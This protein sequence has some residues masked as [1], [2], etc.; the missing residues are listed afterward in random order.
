MPLPSLSILLM[1]IL[2]PLVAGL[3][4]FFIPRLRNEFAFAGALVTFYYA[5][6]IFLLS[7]H[8]VMT[9]DYASIGPVAIGLR[10]DGLSA[11][12]LLALAFL[13]LTAVSFSLRYMRGSPGVGAF[14][15]FLLFT[16][17]A[18]AGV[19]MAGDLMLVLF[20]WGFLA[21]VLYG[22]LFLSRKDSAR[23]AMK[24]FI[25][26]AA[27]DLLMMTGIGILLF[28]LGSS[29]IAPELRIPLNSG[30]A[31]WAFLLLAAGAL[32]KAGSMPFHTWIP[33]AAETAPA[34]FLGF[35]PGAVDKLLGIY[36]LMRISTYIFDLSSSMAIRNV[37]MGIG[38]LTVL[39]AVL[40]AMVQKEA[41]RLLSFHAVSQ[42]GYM[43]LGIGTGN[44]IGIAGG[45]FH[46]VNHALYKS[47]LFY[48]TGAI[49]HWT[50]ETRLDRLGGLANKMPVTTISFL[51]AALAIS[52]VPPL[53]GF[54]SK[55]LVYQGILQLGA[56]GNRIYPLF[57]VAAMLGSV[58]TLASFLKLLH[59]IFL[60]AGSPIT[61]KVRE[62]GLPMWLPNILQA[63]VC[64]VFGVFALS[65][66]MRL[67]ILPSLH[68]DDAAMALGAGWL[69][70]FYQP[71]LVTGLLLIGIALGIVIY[72]VGTVAKPKTR[73]VFVGGEQLVGEEARMPGTEFYGPL[74]QLGPLH[75][76]FASAETGAYDMYNIALK[77]ARG[78]SGFVFAYVDRTVDKFYLVASDIVMMLGRGVQ[79]FA[80]WFFLL[81]LI[82]LFVFAGTGNLTA[83]QY[84]AI[85]LMV[86]A[87]LIAL[88]EDSFPRYM[89]LI[90]LTQLGFI[91]LAF[92]RGGT[93]GALSGL[94]QIYNSAVA[95]A[96]IFLAW[97]LLQRAHP[98][99]RISDY[100]GISETMPMVA[101][102]FIIGGL[103]L[104]G[105]PPSGNFFSKYLLASIY[106][107][108]MT[109]T[110]IIIFVAMLMLAVHLRIIS[111]SMFGKPN[112]ELHGRRDRLYYVTLGAIILCL[113]NIVLAKPIIALLSWA[114]GVSVQ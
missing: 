34:S 67:F 19:F 98:S 52:G 62:V 105:M 2:I 11:F 40:M 13:G 50:K 55:W 110:M 45:L 26:A 69:T 104:A 92:A 108:N 90:V 100:R 70:G 25:I 94:F 86:G 64:V 59:S 31:I 113:S 93:I 18:A 24:G 56:E 96:C 77:V 4:S 53:N 88:V 14:Y 63:A 89:V 71:S 91:I 61:E 83:I 47:T 111:Q 15:L 54:V 76:L 46:M 58:F 20:F 97:R 29:Q 5:L 42:V 3:L 36:L 48:S 27:A 73:D 75:A 74:K 65:V 82:P 9:Y 39:A 66:P 103:S 80:G 51:V 81:L 21:A 60:G 68:G 16:I 8:G 23:V 106:P 30:P 35:V 84:G 85:A 99:P 43:V 109:Y 44:P 78:V 33:D 10:V 37:L 6:R 114:L 28:G 102:G 12:V 22:M 41:F 87:S 1:P 49:E 57:L 101:M 79:A 7:R 17:A 32:A 112:M 107:E 95:Y 72:L 38:A